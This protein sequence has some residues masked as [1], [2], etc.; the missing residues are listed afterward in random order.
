[1]MQLFFDLDLEVEF[2]VHQGFPA[3]RDDPGEPPYIEIIAVRYN[4]Q[5]LEL[6]DSDL[7]RLADMLYEQGVLNDDGH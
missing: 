6:T 7:D 2:D 4:G 1:M 5:S 3:T